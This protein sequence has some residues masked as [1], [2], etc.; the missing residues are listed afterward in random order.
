MGFC[1]PG[2]A[3]PSSLFAIYLWCIS[4]SQC[5]FSSRPPPQLKLFQSLLPPFYSDTLLFQPS[6]ALPTPPHTLHF[7]SPKRQSWPC[8]VCCALSALERW[9]RQLWTPPD[10]SGYSLYLLRDSHRAVSYLP[11]TDSHFRGVTAPLFAQGKKLGREIRKAQ[12]YPAGSL[13]GSVY[14]TA[15]SIFSSLLFTLTEDMHPLK[16][17]LWHLLLL[18]RWPPPGFLAGSL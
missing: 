17:L 16:T 8:P 1:L 4:K 14:G 5:S 11:P 6:K 10:A 12:G 15:M 3:A 9:I 7:S 18:K 2:R 13:S